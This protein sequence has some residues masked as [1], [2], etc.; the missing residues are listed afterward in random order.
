VGFLGVGLEDQALAGAPAAGVHQ[1]VEAL[2][3]VVL[4]ARREFL[5]PETLSRIEARS[6]A[7]EPRAASSDLLQMLQGD[8][9]S[10]TMPVAA[11]MTGTLGGGRRL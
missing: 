4:I 2:G 7:L 1:R 11:P 3:E 10:A 9:W 8:L 5:A 6:A